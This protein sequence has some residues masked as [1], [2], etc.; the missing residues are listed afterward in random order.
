MELT[1][2]LHLVLHLQMS[3]ATPPTHLH[4]CRGSTLLLHVPLCHQYTLCS[5]S[6]HDLLYW[7][8]C[9]Q[10]RQKHISWCS[11]SHLKSRL[12]YAPADGSIICNRMGQSLHLLSGPNTTVRLAHV[13]TECTVCIIILDFDLCS[14]ATCFGCYLQSSSAILY[15][16]TKAA[17]QH[18]ITRNTDTIHCDILE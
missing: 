5:V 9:W 15:T 6:H 18:I 2:Q 12:Y 10:H 4:M 17:L 3:S 8:S 13:D 16:I 7:E 14:T 11:I 1:T